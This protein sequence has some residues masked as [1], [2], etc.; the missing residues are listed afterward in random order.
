M[1]RLGGTLAGHGLVDRGADVWLADATGQPITRAPTGNTLLAPRLGVSVVRADARMSEDDP[2]GWTYDADDGS[3][4][5]A[6]DR[7][8]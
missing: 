3:T 7:L 4:P 8:R 5:G 1:L 2:A 6:P